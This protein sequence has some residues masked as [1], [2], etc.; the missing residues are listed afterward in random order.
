MGLRS[1]CEPDCGFVAVAV[2][3]EV[4]SRRINRLIRHYRARA[5]ARERVQRALGVWD[6]LFSCDSK[7]VVN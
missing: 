4:I 5:S 2:S 7:T 6:V 1:S 3:R